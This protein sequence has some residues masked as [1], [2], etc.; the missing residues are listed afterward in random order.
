M[1]SDIFTLLDRHRALDDSI[2]GHRDQFLSDWDG[3]HPFVESFLGP[4]LVSPRLQEILPKGYLYY[5]ED[6]VVLDLIRSFHEKREGNPL[7][8]NNVIAGPGSSA[9]LVAFSFWLLQ[10]GFREIHY[11]PPLYYS[12]HFFL[13][14]LNTWLRPISKH[15]AFESGAKFNLPSKRTVLL[16]SDPIWYAGRQFPA[17]TIRQIG[18]WQARTGSLVFVDGSFQF[19][20]WDGI[21][22]EPTSILDPELTFR[23]ISPTK[24]LGIPFYRFAYILCPFRFHRDFLFIY[25]NI[26]GGASIGDVKFAKRALDVLA[27]DSSNTPFTSFLKATY[28][29]LI[30]AALIRTTIAP[31]CG[32]FVFALPSATLSGKI[33]MDQEFFELQGY[34]QYI[35][36]NLMLANRFCSSTLRPA[37]EKSPV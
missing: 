5:N 1:K 34:P 30:K 15:Q 31:D 20:Q 12:F 13:R 18:E 10:Q 35:R 23:L 16:I 11:I 27:S 26:V 14:Q 2:S 22:S 29:Q 17:E 9:F 25:E 4:E 8:R 36:I 6:Y 7:S 19:M 21:R 37:T 28:D 24:S 33:S 3:G 32:Y